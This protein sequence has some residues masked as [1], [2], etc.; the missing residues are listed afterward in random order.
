MIPALFTAST[1]MIGNQMYVDTVS[2][3]IANVNT[4]GFKKNRIDFQDILYQELRP[5]GAEFVAGSTV[6]TGISIGMGSRPTSV[7]KIFKQGD[8]V[9]T[10]NTFDVAIE[11]DGFLQVSMPD[12]STAYTRDGA[13][14]LDSNSQMVTSDG[15]F[16]I[17]NITI[18]AGTVSTTIGNDGT[19]SVLDQTGASTNIGS[20]QLASFANPQGLKAMGKNLFIETPASGSA[21]LGTPG[22]GGL[23]NIAQGFLEL[24][25][26]QIVEEMVNLILAQRAYEMNSKAI[27]VGDDMLQTAGQ[28][29]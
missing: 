14:K 24:S 11:G 18:P 21:T 13:I 16:L 5:A 8:L 19:V 23:G 3:N 20:L 1:G 9:N 12:G 29:R 26:V 4:T 7:A 2:N 15:F 22:A 25:N 6:P 10:G 28:L 27:R 17:P